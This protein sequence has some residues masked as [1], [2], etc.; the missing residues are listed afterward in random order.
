MG[1]FF[2]NPDFRF[3]P[4]KE[5]LRGRR[6]KDDR[7]DRYLNFEFLSNLGNRGLSSYFT[8]PDT[9]TQS[10]SNLFPSQFG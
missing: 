6:G 9:L 1:S 8:L 3:Y 5:L 2:S 7:P 4:E 10:Q